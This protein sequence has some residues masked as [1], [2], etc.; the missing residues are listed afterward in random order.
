MSYGTCKLCGC[1]DTTPCFHPDH[2]NCWWITDDHEICSH[3]YHTDIKN[4]PATQRPHTNNLF[5][6]D[7][8]QR[9]VECARCGDVHKWSDR[10]EVQEGI[11]T[12]YRCP[13]C[14]DESYINCESLQEGG[15]TD[16]R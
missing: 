16:A 4:D 2:G 3:C 8:P 6:P 11:W 9:E 7:D 12:V 10:L 1:T 13:V 5:N 15:E 14:S